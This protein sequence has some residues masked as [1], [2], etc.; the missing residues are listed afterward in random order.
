[1][2]EWRPSVLHTHNPGANFYGAL[3]G[4]LAGIPAIIC[5]RHGEGQ[6]DA[7]VWFPFLCH[8]LVAVSE[9]VRARLLSRWQVPRRRVVTIHNGVDAGRASSLPRAEARARLGLPEGVPVAITV[10]RLAPEKDH[11]TLLRAAAGLRARLP[12]LHCLLVGG[13]R[14][15]AGLRQQAERLG[16]QSSVLFLGQR[17]DVAELL[18]AADVF[19]LPSLQE[20]LSIAVLE[21]MSAGLPVVATAVGGNSLLVREGQT[22]FL[23]PPRDADALAKAMEA[24]LTQPERASQLGA[25]G[26]ARV[27]AEF[28]VE[29]TARRYL[30]LYGEVLGMRHRRAPGDP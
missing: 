1:V 24:V 20:G 10:A 18:P 14:L 13:G 17:T 12:E 19:V 27:Q 22:G 23:A 25:A 15:E 16:L 6:S 8:R 28:S 2:R 5:T 30:D 3:A 26:R 4:R 29:D 21:A 9:G 7:A 11:L